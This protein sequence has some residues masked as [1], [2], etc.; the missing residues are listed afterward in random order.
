[1]STNPIRII[2]LASRSD[3]RRQIADR[4][5]RL[6]V[7]GYSFL[8]AVNGKAQ[9]DHPL[10]AHYDP[11]AR[12]RVKGRGRDLKPSQLGCFAS[13]YLLWQECAESG[14]PL[15]VIEDDAILKENFLDALV[16][17]PGLAETWPLVWLYEYDRPGRDPSMKV[18]KAGPFTLM[19]K[20][21]QHSCSVAYLL[22]PAGA[23]A[24]LRHGQTWVYPLDDT[25]FRFSWP[26]K[27]VAVSECRMRRGFMTR[28]ARDGSGTADCA[29]S[30]IS[31]PGPCR[32][33]GG[34]CP[35]REASPRRPDR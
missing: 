24:L 19:R 14:R 2:S 5:D 8:D 13:H 28:T 16:Q 27:P 23:A 10:F 11:I 25:M 20:L 7:T 34:P 17:A 18:G 4:F 31:Y 3:W 6:G 12:A 22:S 21:K 15:I 26:P 9:P 32:P 1:M 29:A 30:A 35:A 33:R